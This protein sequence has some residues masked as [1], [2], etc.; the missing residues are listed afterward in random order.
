MAQKVFLD[1]NIFIRFL[2]RDNEKMYHD[3]L[4]FFELIKNGKLRPY[5]S[6]IVILETIFVLTKIYKFPKQDVLKDMKLLW[7]L[8]NLT[9][10]EV[11]DTKKALKYYQKYSVKYQNCLIASQVPE[12]IKLVTYD[13]DF[14]KIKEI[15]KA[16]PADFL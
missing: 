7:H 10:I 13:R 3:C 14:K 8:R 12:K 6:N 4:N 1:S 2:T 9:L 15:Q 16:N 5:T 11:T